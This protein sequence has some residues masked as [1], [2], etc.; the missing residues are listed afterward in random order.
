MQQ[1]PLPN[2]SLLARAL[3]FSEQT[4]FVKIGSRKE[5]EVFPKASWFLRLLSPQLRRILDTQ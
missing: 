4:V 1:T 2:P 3:R 5:V